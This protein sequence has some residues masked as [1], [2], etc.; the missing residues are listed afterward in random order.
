MPS[1]IFEPISSARAARLIAFCVLLLGVLHAG[2]GPALAQDQT[3]SEADRVAL[4]SSTKRPPMVNT[5]PFEDIARRTKE[6]VEQGK[7]DAT[8]TVELSV[9]AERNDDGTFKPETVKLTWVSSNVET[10]TTLAQQL[11]V[12]VSQSKILSVLE[13]AKLMRMSLKLDRR[14]VSIRMSV[15]MASEE[16]A[17]SYAIS[18]E[19]LLSVAR[20]T[21]EG[22]A[23]GELYNSLKFQ[24]DGKQFVMTFEMPTQAV[25]K[26]ISDALAKKAARNQD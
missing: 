13:G 14:N 2:G 26:I 7:L 18:Y 11:V 25:C 12:A 1:K 19:T 17:Q 16:H 24:S 3:G 22:T 15:E 9:V 4:E 8:N 21:K 23:E 20:R 6:L 10:V 5:M